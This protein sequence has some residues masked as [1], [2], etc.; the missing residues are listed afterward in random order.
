MTISVCREYPFKKFYHHGNVDN[1]LY[2]ALVLPCVD[3][4]G[5]DGKL[6]PSPYGRFQRSVGRPYTI[7]P[8]CRLEYLSARSYS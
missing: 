8:E 7:N 2:T 1:L 6:I 4:F 3:R 5:A